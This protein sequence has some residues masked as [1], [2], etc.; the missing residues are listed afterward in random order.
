MLIVE[1][2]FLL[3]RRDDGKA[4]SDMARR[5]YGLVAAVVTDL[6]LAQRIALSDD[7]DPRVTVLVP[8]P[9]GHP[10]LD[11]AIARLQ[12]REGKRLS[13]LMVD[14]KLAVEEPVA[15]ALA[16]AG[17]VDIEEKRAL[18]LVPARYPVRDPGPERRVRERLR[19]VLMGGTA[20]PSDSAILAIL[21]GLG[22]AHTVLADEMGTL[23][24]AQLKDR[25]EE[26]ATDVKAGD[27]V[28]KAIEAM[29]IAI[30][31]AVVVPAVVTSS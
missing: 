8:A 28:A 12:Q 30:M 25:I 15:R 7:K 23:T 4:A 21:Q 26:V 1:E 16:A 29:N 17:V 9:V 24:K 18:G 22:I 2:M 14:T 27:A 3:M 19:A 5:F 6:A 10:A 20:E 31:S 13:A 11:V